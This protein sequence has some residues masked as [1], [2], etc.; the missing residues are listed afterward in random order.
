MWLKKEGGED[1]QK[2]SLELARN[3]DKFANAYYCLFDTNIH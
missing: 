2:N 3:I 1:E